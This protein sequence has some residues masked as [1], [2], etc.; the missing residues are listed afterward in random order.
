MVYFFSQ[1]Q[2][3]SFT[4][5][6]SQGNKKCL[7][8]PFSLSFTFLMDV[9]VS[10]VAAQL[11]LHAA[12]LSLCFPSSLCCLC[13]LSSALIRWP[14][15]LHMSDEWGLLGNVVWVATFCLGCG[16]PP[17]LAVGE[18]KGWN[19]TALH[20]GEAPPALWGE[21]KWAMPLVHAIF[22]QANMI[23]FLTFPLPRLSNFVIDLP[24]LC[25]YFK[26]PLPHCQELTFYCGYQHQD[27]VTMGY[28]A[29]I[30]S[31][32]SATCSIMVQW[33]QGCCP[34]LPWLGLEGP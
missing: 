17:L 15:H 27:S 25:N 19:Q 32:I 9:S 29:A 5:N 28:T 16:S 2:S 6:T 7:S 30:W 34:M 1:S 23:C 10:S 13:S 20:L 22:Q 4:K 24:H 21:D 3:A 14:K 26:G 18:G 12:P 33:G 8:S 11:F 31:C